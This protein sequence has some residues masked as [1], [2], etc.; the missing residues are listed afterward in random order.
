MGH[1]FKFG[2]QEVNGHGH[3]RQVIDLE[4][5]LQTGS[6]SALLSAVQVSG[7]PGRLLYTSL[8]HSQPT[9]FA[10][11][12][13]TSPDHT[14][15]LAQHFRSSGLLCCRSN[16]LELATRQSPWCSAQQLQFQTTSE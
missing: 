8:R 10:V 14:T 16:G 5:P 6:H 3:T 2:C 1:G 15:S 4:Y 12:Y 11:S 7:V 13:S 9:S